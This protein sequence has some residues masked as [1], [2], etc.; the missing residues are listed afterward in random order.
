[1]GRPFFSQK[2]AKRQSLLMLLD[3]LLTLVYPQACAVCGGSVEQRRFGV[4]CEACWGATTIFTGR[5]RLCW[6]C[7]VA[8]LYDEVRCRRCDSH[9]F[10][11]ARA[12]GLYEGALRESTL[13]LKRRP[14]LPQHVEELLIA[15]A[16][17]EPLNA[18]TRIV[19]V[20]L[21][22]ERLRAR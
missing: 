14:Y 13:H 22:P 19:P 7:G 15:T 9:S 11:A 18:S 8:A 12:V 20:P 6:K 1:M 21:H 10:T 16:R 3:A 17:R 2:K 5:E 4:A